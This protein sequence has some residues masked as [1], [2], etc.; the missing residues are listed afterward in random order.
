MEKIK[1]IVKTKSNSNKIIG[2]DKDKKAYLVQVKPLPENNKANLEV[3]KLFRKKTK[4]LV[5]IIAGHKN[6]EK[7]LEII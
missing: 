3:I 6:K 5:K 4:K 2:Y 7:I 1:V